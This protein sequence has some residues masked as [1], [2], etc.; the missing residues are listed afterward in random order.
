MLGV[1]VLRRPPAVRAPLRVEDRL[2]ERQQAEIVVSDAPHRLVHDS[3]TLET[4]AATAKDR[5]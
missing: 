4:T 3:G 5:Y 1:T 2:S